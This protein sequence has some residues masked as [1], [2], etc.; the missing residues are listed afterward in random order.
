METAGIN[1]IILYWI[2]G[3]AL[4]TEMTEMGIKRVHLALFLA[5]LR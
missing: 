2:Q 4:P 5:Y 1:F 3:T